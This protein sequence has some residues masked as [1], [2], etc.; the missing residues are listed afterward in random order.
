MIKSCISP[1]G[2][3]LLSGSE[4]G[5]PVMWDINKNNIIKQ[6]DANWCVNFK[7]PVTDVAWNWKYHMVAVAGFGED[8]EFP[9]LL[10]CFEH[11]SDFCI[12][13]SLY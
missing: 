9:I 10:Y 8:S 3:Y 6:I 2:Q 7:G 5:K 12:S 13:L 11:K 1:D 4:N